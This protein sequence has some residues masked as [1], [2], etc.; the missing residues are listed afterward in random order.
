MATYGSGSNV[1]WSFIPEVTYNVLPG[2]PIFTMLRAKPSKIQLKR[3]NYTTDEV[4]ADRGISDVRLG[5][6]AAQGDLEGDLIVGPW[7]AFIL[8]SLQ[9]AAWTAVQTPGTAIV[10]TATAADNSL[11]RPSGSFVTDGYNVNDE[12]AVSG[13]VTNPANFRAKIASVSALK[14]T[15][16]TPALLP[17][18]GSGITLVN[19]AG[20]SGAVKLNVGSNTVTPGKTAQC[21][22]TLTSFQLENGFTDI[23]QFRQF[24]G[25]CISKAK[26]SIKPGAMAGVTFTFEGASAASSTVT[27]STSQTAALTNSPLTPS[28]GFIMEGS[29]VNAY[30]TGLELELSNGL[31]PQKVVGSNITPA[32]FNGRSDLKGTVTALFKDLTL[33]NKFLSETYSS[34]DVVLLDPNGTD[35]HHIYLP[36]IKYT[37]GELNPPKDGAIPVS[38]PF[39]ALVST[40]GQLQVASNIVYQKS[41]V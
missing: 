29:A 39:Q 2:S 13:F 37:G 26:W 33:L 6:F 16:Y 34:I 41:N 12:I 3:D 23:S 40:T 24:G 4:R 1:V 32:M 36:R 22:T 7:D 10:I 38:L 17:S 9:G 15:L 27:V 35:F 8:A 11:N 18:P 5:E 20:A 21:G 14:I 28:V 31:G 30:I 25:M 19:E